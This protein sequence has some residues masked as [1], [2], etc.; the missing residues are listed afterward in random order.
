MHVAPVFEGEEMPYHL[1]VTLRDV[2]GEVLQ[3]QKLAAIH[4]AGM[5]LADL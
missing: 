2:T 4:K 5:E 1:I 3:Q